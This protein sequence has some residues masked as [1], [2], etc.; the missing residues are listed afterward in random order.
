MA[1]TARVSPAKIPEE[2]VLDLATLVLSTV[3][4]V[5]G[6]PVGGAI[7]S[8]LGQTIDQQLLGPGPRHGPRVGDLA[9]QSS[10]Y[11]TAIPKIFGKMR[12]AGSIIWST[13]LQE[14]SE[15]IGAKG[16]P[17]AVTYSYSASFA[18]ALSSRPIG[19]VRRIWADGKLVRSEEGEFS[20]RTGFRICDGSEDQL[21]DPLIATIEGL[22][23][24]PAYRGVAL[25]VFEDLDLG[26]FGNRIPFLTF[27][28][29]AD[30][31]AVGLG[32]ILAESSAGAIAAPGAD[33]EVIG[34]AAHGSSMAAAVEPLMDAF[35]VELTDNGGSLVIPIAEELTVQEH[36]CGCTA[37]VE[38]APRRERSQTPS[39]SLP[40]ALSL[41][42]YDP[43]RDYQQAAARA[44]QEGGGAVAEQLEVPAVL[45]ASRAKALAEA[46]LARRW[47]ERDTLRLRIPPSFLAA[48]P[49]TR[50]RL[51]AESWRAATV[52]IEGFAVVAELRPQYS[53]LQSL[54][55]A[56]GRVLS[57][58]SAELEPTDL[59]LFELS[60]DQ[61]GSRE[62]PV[63][64]VAASTAA[65]RWRAV[66]LDIQIGSIAFKT[67]SP[68]AAA[69]IGSALTVLPPGPASLFDLLN[70]V[71]VA[72]TNPGAWLESRDDDAL[73]AG[74][75]LA[76]LGAEM[77]Q[78]GEALPIGPGKFRLGRLL[79]GRRGSEWAM[80]AHQPGDRL[81]LLDSLRLV[82]LPVTSDLTGS[83]ARATP[84]GIADDGA[85]AR[86]IVVTGEALRPPSPV[87]LRA[88]LD[89]SGKLTCSWNRRS[90][91]GWAWLDGVDAPLGCSTELYRIT[92]SSS[93]GSAVREVSRPQL[94]LD[95][96]DVAELGDGQV[97]ISVVQVG[98][99]AE[100]RPALAV[101]TT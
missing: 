97:Q 55:A 9:V 34:F 74:E 96:S 4:T 38:P 27:E 2:G 32:R 90:A 76:V 71:D 78:F 95:A 25:A 85:A 3:G 72:L 7:G 48:K 77:F 22:D 67:R 46:W 26:E 23:S 63:V 44:S 33:D 64:V 93:A 53:R 41:K 65:S 49:G 69:V 61:S 100:S 30:A 92:L 99:L 24:T 10:S 17:D 18:V 56:P 21:A 6:G 60:D 81:V 11:G 54:P 37:E 36:E 79:R 101:I 39:Q 94:E 87:H 31:A 19:A 88:G 62:A 13:D 28:V 57:S 14:A 20:V 51:G 86:Q 16:Q 59:A 84:M 29:E 40:A 98:D 82:R 83:L 47:A 12:V 75:N 15:T 8:L 52:T 35:D 89:A 42:Y 5:L 66:P 70:S 91:L 50:I 58:P 43:A 80:S 1:G 68:A 45:D 73:I